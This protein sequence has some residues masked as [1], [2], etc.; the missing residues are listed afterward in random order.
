VGGGGR[1][2]NLETVLAANFLPGDARVV[3][4]Y[5]APSI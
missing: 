3:C 4:K 5:Q 1:Q 2:P